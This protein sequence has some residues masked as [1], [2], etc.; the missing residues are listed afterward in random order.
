MSTFPPAHFPA[1]IT[2]GSRGCKPFEAFGCVHAYDVRQGKG[3]SLEQYFQYNIT[4][5]AA[6]KLMPA[7]A[8]V[9]F[10]PPNEGS[11][12]AVVNYEDY[13]RSGLLK[14]QLGMN[15][16]QQVE[17]LFANHPDMAFGPFHDV[18]S[19]DEWEQ[20]RKLHVPTTK[21]HKNN[22]GKTR[23]ILEAVSSVGVGH[24]MV[25]QLLG[26]ETHLQ[27][28]RMY[29]NELYYGGCL[30]FQPFKSTTEGSSGLL[31]YPSGP[32]L[33]TANIHVLESESIPCF[34][35]SSSLKCQFPVAGCVRQIDTHRSSLKKEIFACIR[36][37]YHAYVVKCKR[38]ENLKC[39]L[40]H[41]VTSQYRLT[42]VSLSPHIEGE[43]LFS[44]ERGQV[45]HIDL[46]KKVTGSC[47][48]SPSRSF[49]PAY[50]HFTGHPRLAFVHTKDQ[51]YQ[52]DFRLPNQMDN[53]KIPLFQLPSSCLPTD[54]YFCVAMQHPS[55]PFY[56]YLA[57]Q[58]YLCLM[59]ER[60]PQ[61]SVLQ[62]PHLLLT[63]PNYLHITPSVILPNMLTS[64]DL[65][66]AASYSSREVHC[67]QSSSLHGQAPFST[68]PPWKLQDSSAWFDLMSV[69]PSRDEELIRERISQPLV[70]LCAAKIE[71]DQKQTIT[72]F[73]ISEAGDVYQQVLKVSDDDEFAESLQR[74][75]LSEHCERKC[76]D[77]IDRLVV[78]SDRKEECEISLKKMKT[79][80]ILKEIGKHLKGKSG[81]C[82][83]CQ[84]GMVKSRQGSFSCMQ[85][86]LTAD[87]S[88][89]LNP[90][91][92][93]PRGI[94]TLPRQKKTEYPTVLHLR[95]VKK[96]DA[97]RCT[98]GKRLWNMWYAD[99]ETSSKRGARKLIKEEKKT[100]K[101]TPVK[102]LQKISN[103]GSPASTNHR[104]GTSSK[105]Q[106][107]APSR[108]LP[109]QPRTPD[110]AAV[111]EALTPRK[112]SIVLDRLPSSQADSVMLSDGIEA[113]GQCPRVQ[114]TAG[115]Q[116]RLPVSN[117]ESAML[118]GDT[119][120]QSPNVWDTAQ[121]Q[122]HSAM[123]AEDRPHV[124]PSHR[125]IPES[126]CS[127]SSVD[128]ERQYQKHQ[129]KQQERSEQRQYNFDTNSPNESPVE[130]INLISF[131]R[132]P[133]KS[134]KKKSHAM[135]F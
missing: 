130:N 113:E 90:S 28:E 3:G 96:T 46:T 115:E 48:V 25:Q 18:L 94:L 56:H 120:A 131:L 122:G 105:M 106:L 34:K 68:R 93:L 22:L 26:E 70:G 61:H 132:K 30:S 50:A 119:E 33:D 85:C 21:E 98:L 95:S 102:H 45:N 54:Q 17:G 87:Q 37:D 82:C 133:K 76:R 8:C 77:F 127:L 78:A 49:T 84:P 111:Q 44:N 29:H 88:S 135:G 13:I 32:A 67:F 52:L 79:K 74:D 75:K 108:P 16:E 121:T 38:K 99:G 81:G 83:M 20:I 63:P 23:N 117:A 73:Q 123:A 64:D 58:H 126:P 7:G 40:I 114:D 47:A 41:D 59:D 4:D 110:S 97:E 24:S 65:L 116:D 51:A 35:P 62:W 103:A 91:E 12:V 31:F 15:I 107:Q 19:N 134:L 112:V 2:S 6:Q 43:L 104:E 10:L 100:P 36:A 118:S 60:F 89:T 86:G 69:I 109:D 125:D 128:T 101:K 80:K 129:P 124:L 55:N 92:G 9:P 72:V 5:E 53:Q 71:D 42:S 57:T 14:K 27:I 11:S 39:E 66:L 1:P